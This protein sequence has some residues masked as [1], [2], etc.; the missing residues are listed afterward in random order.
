MLEPSESSGGVPLK[1]DE[2]ETQ[3]GEETRLS[4]R[5]PVSRLFPQ[6]YV[7]TSGRPPLFGESAGCLTC[8]D[9]FFF[10]QQKKRKAQPQDSRGG[11]KKYK[12]FK[13]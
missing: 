10:L 13:F 4:L 7:A 6:T 11:S 1:V 9:L 8:C 2:A 3:G 12:E 5:I